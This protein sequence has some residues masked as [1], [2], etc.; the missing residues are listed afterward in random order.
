MWLKRS[1]TLLCAAYLG[2]L[3]ATFLA[4]L[5]LHPQDFSSATH[6]IF[7]IKFAV[8][9]LLWTLPGSYFVAVV[10]D[11]LRSRHS[12]QMS[13]AISI[14]SGVIAGGAILWIMADKTV[15]VFAIGCYF[16]LA[17]AGTWAAINRFLISNCQW[18]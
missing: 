1:I 16:G 3:L 12:E 13:Y 9:L 8:P 14:L 7:P 17:T 4:M 18:P 2:G 6:R 5:A 11:S 10:Y 15:L